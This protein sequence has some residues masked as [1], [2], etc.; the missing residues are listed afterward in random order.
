[1]TNEI[2]AQLIKFVSDCKS[3][4]ELTRIEIRA[5]RIQGGELPA[6]LKDIIN[7]KRNE[8]LNK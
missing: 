3:E 4:T 1:M 8:L 5:L 2:K 6:D 7:T